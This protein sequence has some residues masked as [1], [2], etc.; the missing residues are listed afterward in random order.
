MGLAELLDIRP[1]VT[2]VIGGGGKTTL[3]RTLGEELAEGGARVLLCATTKIFPFEDLPNL[4]NPSEKALAEALAARRPVCAGALV[5]GTGKLTAPAIPMARLAELAD[6]VLAEADGSAGRPLKA[7]A[8]HEPVIPPEA[9]QAVC[10]VGASGFG[11]PIAEAAHRPALYARLSGVPEDAPAA[12]EAEAAVLLAE[13]LH[14][15]V[16]V[17]QAETAEAREQASALA[18]LLSCPAAAGSLMRKE[19][20]PCW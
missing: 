1:G 16:F 20:F 18:A 6:Y 10:V 12:P 15:R 4:I 9:N 8:P 2:A 14:T 19:Y 5:P 3:L 17:N 7:H 13:G 11:R